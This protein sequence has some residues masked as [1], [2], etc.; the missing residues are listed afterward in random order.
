MSFATSQYVSVHGMDCA[1]KLAGEKALN[2]LKAGRV[3]LAHGTFEDGGETGPAVFG[4]TRNSKKGVLMVAPLGSVDEYW[5]SHLCKHPQL[6]ARILRTGKERPEGD[7]ELLRFWRVLCQP[8]EELDPNDLSCLGEKGV[9]AAVKS[10]K[11]LQDV[12]VSEN[13]IITATVT[14]I[15]PAIFKDKRVTAFT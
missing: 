7:S 4:V 8:G 12:V 9:E 3:T 2:P 6:R 5:G 1:F 10:W 13:H 14:G 11:F 15:D